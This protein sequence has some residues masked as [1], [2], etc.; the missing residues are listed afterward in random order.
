M[1][2]L[3]FVMYA[4]GA[5]PM[6]GLIDKWHQTKIDRSLA[7]EYVKIK[8]E[9]ADPKYNLPRQKELI[10]SMHGRYLKDME[11]LLGKKTYNEI[12]L[13]YQYAELRWLEYAFIKAVAEKEGW[14]VYYDP[15]VKNNIYY[16]GAHVD[17]EDLF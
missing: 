12:I 13:K 4:L 17:V 3:M 9:Q 11:K 8:A 7:E 6:Y 14:E 5:I 16:Y 2:S 10:D 1:F 15:I